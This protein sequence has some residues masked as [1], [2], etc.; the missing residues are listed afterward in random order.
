MDSERSATAARY[1]EPARATEE[2]ARHHQPGRQVSVHAAVFLTPTDV[3]LSGDTLHLAREDDTLSTSPRRT[4]QSTQP[5]GTHTLSFLADDCIR[6]TLRGIVQPYDLAA[7]LEKECACAAQNGYVLML[8]DAT[9]VT[10]LPPETRRAASKLTAQLREIHGVGVVY[11]TSQ[12]ARVLFG[13]LL[14]ALRV[15]SRDEGRFHNVFVST[16][17]EALRC[18][19]ESRRKY[20]SL[21]RT[22]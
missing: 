4:M 17:A 7:I 1:H 2:G 15:L 9:A 8:I 10:G 6:L 3:G 18:I 11:G 19:D 5:I 13:M 21:S 12:T 22:L 16:E 20:Q 14:G